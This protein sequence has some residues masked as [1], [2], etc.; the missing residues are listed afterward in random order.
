MRSI[1]EIDFYPSVEGH[2]MTERMRDEAECCFTVSSLKKKED[3]PGYALSGTRA[4]V[5]A[6]FLK[7]LSCGSVWAGGVSECDLDHARRTKL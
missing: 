3:V 4:A 1:V 7:H 6:S 5:G 2:T